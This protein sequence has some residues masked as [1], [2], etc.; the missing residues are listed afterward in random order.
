M[1]IKYLLFCFLSAEKAA[2]LKQAVEEARDDI[3]KYKRDRD[4]TFQEQQAQVCV[5]VCVCA[6]A[7]VCVCLLLRNVLFHFARGTA[8]APH[9][10]FYCVL[11]PVS[12][13]S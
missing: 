2:R 8:I 1:F 7:C 13:A 11:A 10:T 5:C 6:C 12:C 4:K 3:D 9:T